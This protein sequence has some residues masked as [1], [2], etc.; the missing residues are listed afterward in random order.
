M[1]LDVY[2]AANRENWDE[3]VP[4]RTM[5]GSMYDLAGFTA[6]G[7]TL[8]SIQVQELGDVSGKSL[9][10]LQCHFGLDTL[11]GLV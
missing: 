1:P 3:R 8:T 4:H 5:A 7:S 2:R 10:H 9:L 11:R 6:G